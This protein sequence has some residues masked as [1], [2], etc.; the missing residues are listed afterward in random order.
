[1]APLAPLAAF[2]DFK[3]RIP[4]GIPD[5]DEAR[6]QAN[7]HDASVLIR[8]EAG[9]TWEGEE[10]P[11]I[12]VAICMAVARRAF[13]NPDE[14]RSEAID[15][16]VTSFANPDIYLTKKE[17]R[18]I[19]KAAG[20]SGLWTQGITRT[21]DDLPDTPSVLRDGPWAVDDDNLDAGPGSEL[22]R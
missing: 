19:Q 21:E 13:L 3:D 10:P 4:D 17:L 5:S 18:L 8:V 22:F 6:A 2:E 15:T 9:K 11:E 16:Q 1:M 14:A 20:R 7:L 12:A